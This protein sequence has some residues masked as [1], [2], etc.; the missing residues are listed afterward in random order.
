MSKTKDMTGEVY[1]NLEV[2]YFSAIKNTNSH[3]VCKCTLCNNMTEVS[4]P[5]L[6]SGNT[7]DCGCRKSEKISNLNK[8]HGLSKTSTWNSWSKMHFR[9]K[10]GAKYSQVYGTISVCEEWK[11]FDNFLKDMGERPKGMTLDRIDNTK[12]YSKDNCRWATQAEQNRNRSS[13]VMLTY[14]GETMCAVDWANKLNLH[15]DT[16]RRRLKR[17]L[18]LEL[19][20]QNTNGNK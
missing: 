16:I 20:L 11:S 14:N 17:K 12:G 19:V 1:G 13:N 4:R 7:V 15:R 2:V 18:P 9:I 5:N 3:W 8:T 10:K 6:R